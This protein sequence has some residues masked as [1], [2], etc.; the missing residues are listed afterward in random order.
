MNTERPGYW[1]VR[2]AAFAA[3]LIAIDGDEQIPVSGAPPPADVPIVDGYEYDTPEDIHAAFVVQTASIQATW[4]IAQGAADETNERLPVAPVA[5]TGTASS[6]S[7]A[8]GTL[9]GGAIPPPDSDE[10]TIIAWQIPPPS[11]PAQAALDSASESNERLPINSVALSGTAA[12]TSAASGTL[13]ASGVTL[14]ASADTQLA[15]LLAPDSDHS[16]VLHAAS[17]DNHAIPVDG[18]VVAAPDAPLAEDDPFIAWPEP[19]Y[20]MPDAESLPVASVGL[21]G[22]A[23]STSTASGTLSVSSLLP[24]EEPWTDWVAS[25]PLPLIIEEAAAP[26]PIAI[27]GTASSTSA[28]SGTLSVTAL[29]LPDEP[30]DYEIP[31]PPLILEEEVLVKPVSLAGT[32]SSTSTA[33]GTLSVSGISLDVSLDTDWVAQLAPDRDATAVLLM[34]A[35]GEYTVVDGTIVSAPGD[36]PPGGHDEYL[37]YLYALAP[38]QDATAAIEMAAV[39]ESPAAL[40]AAIPMVI[41]IRGSYVPNTALTGSVGSPIALRGQYVPPPALTGAYGNTISIRGSYDPTATFTG[42]I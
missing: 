17:E 11:H 8:S 20:P 36:E 29:V 18:T 4:H 16:G 21:S 28:A 31:P 37:D 6:T 38:D 10:H 40:P 33:S 5:L 27:T 7:T 23:A 1:V 3:A 22:T 32:A 34:A 39:G 9:T 12:S 41:S 2:G 15:E 25:P 26:A 13:S 19:A 30:V 35:E 24:V 14:D 42:D